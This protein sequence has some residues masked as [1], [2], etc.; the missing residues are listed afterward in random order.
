MEIER[1]DG[2]YFLSECLTC[3]MY[4]IKSNSH[5]CIRSILIQYLG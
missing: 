4:G 5:I 1:D 3:V 2:E